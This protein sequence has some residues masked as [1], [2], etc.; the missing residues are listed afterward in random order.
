MSI[1]SKSGQLPKNLKCVLDS[2]MCPLQII[3]YIKSLTLTLH[4]VN[5]HL[6]PSKWKITISLKLVNH[7]TINVQGFIQCALFYSQPLYTEKSNW[8]H[9]S[10]LPIMLSSA[11]TVLMTLTPWDDYSVPYATQSRTNLVVVIL[12]TSEWLLSK[13]ITV[14]KSI[15]FLLANKNGASS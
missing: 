15:R 4:G 11:W 9:L 6:H 10:L 2:L 1:F 7:V 12:V 14:F 13:C 5:A 8:L 3:N